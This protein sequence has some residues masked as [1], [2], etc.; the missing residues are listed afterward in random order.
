[1][2]TRLPRFA[3]AVCC[4]A[5]AAQSLPA[6][7]DN[8]QG[9]GPRHYGGGGGGAPGQGGP[10]G[11]GGRGFD[12]NSDEAKQYRDAL[13]AFCEKH[14]PRRWQEIEDRI[15]KYGPRAGF[16][17]MSQMSFKFR[18]LQKLEKEDPELHKI[19]VG[20]IEVEDV[21]Y[22]LITDLKNLDKSDEKRA[23]ELRKQLRDENKQY[24]DLRLQERAHRLDRLTRMVDDEKRKLADD[25]KHADL[26]AD[27]RLADL[28]AQGP[29]YFLPRFGRRGDAGDAPSTPQ[30]PTTAPAPVPPANTPPVK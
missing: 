4:M 9:N 11:F 7:A 23:A 19:K 29:D 24:V 18:E 6:R 10:G 17:R 16:A 30:P 5:A 27:Q 21:E 13:K 14:S 25:G 1:M 28:E 20:L 2:N 12:P 26:L 8:P 3:L 15:Q 22:G